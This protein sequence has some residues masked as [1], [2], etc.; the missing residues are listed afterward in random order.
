MIQLRKMSK[1]DVPAVSHLVGAAYEF[2]ADAENYA[3]NQRH[4]L[5]KER[6]VPEWVGPQFLRCR[7]FVAISGSRIVG[8][9]AVNNAEVYELYVHPAYHRH[10]IGT[11]LFRKAE[12]LIAAGGHRRLQVSTTGYAVPF[13]KAMGAKITGKECVTFGPLA[14]WRNT[15]LSKDLSTERE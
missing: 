13:Y 14:G 2:L 11:R 15:V 9:L 6:C 8:V 3:P 5:R 4:R 12:R 7:S 10:G 1:R